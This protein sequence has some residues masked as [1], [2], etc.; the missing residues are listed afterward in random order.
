MILTLS[1]IHQCGHTML[2]LTTI[3]M[4][5]FMP[6]MLPTAESWD[7]EQHLE[8]TSPNRPLYNSCT[9]KTPKV[10]AHLYLYKTIWKHFT[11]LDCLSR[12]HRI[13][14]HPHS[15]HW[16]PVW[17]P[18]FSPGWSSYM[19]HRTSKLYRH[20]PY[21]FAKIWHGFSIRPRMGDIWYKLI[22]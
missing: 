21:L 8:S 11:F 4:E 12:G 6:E 16:T 22:C 17:V 1:K 10:I 19:V 5:P 2:T 18:C 7:F 15:K 13:S 3:W 9:H 20:R 14:A